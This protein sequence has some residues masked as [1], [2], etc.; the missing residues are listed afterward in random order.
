MLRETVRL[1]L[2]RL[3]E[4]GLI[5]EK[6]RSRY[7]MKPGV[8][9]QLEWQAAYARAIQQTVLFTNE[10]LEQGVVRWIPAAKGKRSGGR[11]SVSGK[12]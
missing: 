8:L 11:I 4:E 5:V 1:K 9:Q 10:C 2:K 7:V 12:K 3:L 6:G